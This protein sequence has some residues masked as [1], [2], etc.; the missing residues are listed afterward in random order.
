MRK[1]KLHFKTT[2][3]LLIWGTVFLVCVGFLACSSKK[4]ITKATQEAISTQ[5]TNHKDSTKQTACT[6]EN[7]LERLI[8]KDSLN[9]T[10]VE[11]K[12]MPDSCHDVYISKIVQYDQGQTNTADKIKSVFKDEENTNVELRLEDKQEIE[13]RNEERSTDTKRNE[14]PELLLIFYFLFFLLGAIVGYKIKN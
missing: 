12:P 1:T 5:A 3:S 6:Q 13:V 4:E 10:I 9:F 2:I 14:R 11:F 7:T 8:T